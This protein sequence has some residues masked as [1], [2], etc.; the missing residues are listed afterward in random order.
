[1]P[2]SGDHAV[3]CILES[4]I[5]SP[6]MFL[7]P[8]DIGGEFFT[9]FVDDNFPFDDEGLFSSEEFWDEQYYSLPE[10][11]VSLLTPAGH[12]TT[13]LVTNFLIDSEFMVLHSVGMVC[14]ED[15]SGSFIEEVEEEECEDECSVLEGAYQT[16]VA[17]DSDIKLP[18][19]ASSLS[20]LWGERII[21]NT[22]R[23]PMPALVRASHVNILLDSSPVPL[24]KRV[25]QLRLKSS[26]PLR[27]SLFHS[28]LKQITFLPI[29]TCG[30][31]PSSFV[32]E[33]AQ[34]TLVDPDTSVFGKHDA[35][36]SK[37]RAMIEVR[38][39]GVVV[40]C[41]PEVVEMEEVQEKNTP[42]EVSGV[43]ADQV[44]LEGTFIPIE[45]G[46]SLAVEENAE[47]THT[48]VLTPAD[49]IPS[50]SEEH[51]DQ[52][53]GV[54]L[55]FVDGTC[56]HCRCTPHLP[57]STLPPIVTDA[58]AIPLFFL[59][60]AHCS[61]CTD[62]HLKWNELAM[63]DDMLVETRC[64]ILPSE[65]L[66]FKLTARND[67]R[68]LV[69]E[70]V[71]PCVVLD[72]DDEAEEEGEVERQLVDPPC[73]EGDARWI[74]VSD[75]EDAIDEAETE[76]ELLAG[77]F[78]TPISRCEGMNE[79]WDRPLVQAFWTPSL[80]CDDEAVEERRCVDDS[81]DLSAVLFD[82]YAPNKVKAELLVNVTPPVF[83]QADVVDICD[84]FI[85]VFENVFLL[86]G[87]LPT[88]AEHGWLVAPSLPSSRSP[89][90]EPPPS[91]IFGPS[92]CTLPLL[93][94]S[95]ALQVGILNPLSALPLF[96]G[97]DTTVEQ[98]LDTVPLNNRPAAVYKTG[99]QTEVHIDSGA[100]SLDMT[101][102]SH[103]HR[104]IDDV[105]VDAGGIDEE[106]K[107]WPRG[108]VTRESQEFHN[109]V[110]YISLTLIY[111]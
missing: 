49:D 15:H 31:Q 84:D 28:P 50:S 71:D 63:K 87:R 34:S 37:L 27:P 90:D 77:L 109:E 102:G 78:D 86:N 51:Y 99:E 17:K 59:S 95:S 20:A 82:F 80:S 7:A 14:V 40:D 54:P 108:Q 6:S 73:E 72:I 36:S 56:I 12:R 9:S 48:S 33:V 110:R 22:P 64:R 52:S 53:L 111:S 103:K 43:G 81:F 10:I 57:I 47:G 66:D 19:V 1:M 2:I 44:S 65:M 70:G 29:S 35:M 107:T 101:V 55:E 24:S 42:K 4:V 88:V 94:F 106:T 75:N 61:S 69:A 68:D 11:D 104:P 25:Q 91:A 16:P 30:S 100:A 85:P 41:G 83:D 39:E 60:P 97:G 67:L 62:M 96:S 58:P 93:T 74:R 5:A 26:A 45:F 89:I 92:G 23:G 3:D 38:I 105:P 21:T 79:D 76:M 46:S 13:Q 98:A 18:E 8:T 32:E